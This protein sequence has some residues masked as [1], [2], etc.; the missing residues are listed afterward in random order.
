MRCLSFLL[1]S[2]FLCATIA[3]ARDAREQARIDYLIDSLRSLKGAVFIRNGNE[4][5]AKTA[6]DHLRG[7]LK[8]AGERVKTAEQFIDYCA[9]ASSMSHKPYFI[10]F[11]DGTTQETRFYFQA[12]LREFDAAQPK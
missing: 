12:K 1:L 10:Q 5:D 11:H 4:Y 3:N 2:F 9:S 8:Y 6:C 7:K